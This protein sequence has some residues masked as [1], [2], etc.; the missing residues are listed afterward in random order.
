VIAVIMRT[1]ADI[2]LIFFTEERG[3]WSLVVVVGVVIGIWST[4]VI[5]IGFAITKLF[6]SLLKRIRCVSTFLAEGS[7][8]HR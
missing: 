2:I 7:E 3:I 8:L 1:I 6:K 5:L 4:I